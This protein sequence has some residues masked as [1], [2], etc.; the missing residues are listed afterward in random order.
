MSLESER[1]IPLKCDHCGATYTYSSESISSLGYVQCQNCAYR[2]NLE[3]AQPAG[4]MAMQERYQMPSSAA[5][6]GWSEYYI[7]WKNRPRPIK[8]EALKL[9]LH[10]FAYSLIG[11]GMYFVLMIALVAFL[12][13][14]GIFGVFLFF[15]LVA[16]AVGGINIFLSSA[17][18]SIRCSSTIG[19]VAAHGLFLF[20]V[21]L[22]TG[23]ANFSFVFIGALAGPSYYWPIQIL[24]IALFSF[25]DGV[26]CR[27]VGLMFEVSKEEEKQDSGLRHAKCPMCGSTYAYAVSSIS[28]DG[29]VACQN[30]NRVFPFAAHSKP[31]LDAPVEGLEIA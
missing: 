4:T 26:A 1:R 14:A 2:I 3:G 31:S 12:F 21:L 13:I 24:G 18:W 9:L 29:T 10:G 16:L 22:V 15:G 28:K 23:I 11:L 8:Y 17:I 7:P 25:V 27:T 19:S 5:E 30:C 20:G 6:T